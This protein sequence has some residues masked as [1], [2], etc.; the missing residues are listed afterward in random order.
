MKCT[1]AM[2][3]AVVAFV[4]LSGAWLARDAAAEPILDDHSLAPA[5]P[6]APEK[7]GV[8]EAWALF[9]VQDYNGAMKLLREAAATDPSLPPALLI[10]AEWYEGVGRL[11]ESKEVIDQAAAE[12][13]NDPE[14]CLF[15]ARAALRDR[16]PAKA[17]S[18]YEKAQ[19]LVA[20]FDKNPR[21]KERMEKQ[22]QSGQ[23]ALAM[24]TKDW[25]SAQKA[26]EA[27]LKANPKNVL[28]LR[29]L[30]YCL[31]QQKNPDGAL[32]KLQEAAK[33]DPAASAPQAQLS[34]F[35]QASGDLENARKWMAAAVDAAPKDLKT[36]LA[37]GQLAL[38]TGDVEDARKQANAAMQI[39]PRSADA[40][41]FRGIIAML[42]REY[43][44]AE[45]YFS[46][47]LKQ[48]PENFAYR[49]NL[50][51]ALIAQD[52]KAKNQRA[53]DMAEANARQYPKSA[54]AAA[55]LGW[56]LY[57]LGR[58]DEAERA[59]QGAAAIAISDV[60]AAYFTARVAVDRGRKAEARQMLE[61]AL[62]NPK[63]YVFRRDA[64]T[65]LKQ[66]QK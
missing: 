30:A 35:Y 14:V 25:A 29:R 4:A 12:L 41:F 49:N 1:L 55:T 7:T 45:S 13:P 20:A 24:A 10:M 54:D 23:I 43:E 31:F 28:A 57:R 32:A 58:I 53:L 61:S 22:L 52:D 17:A 37:A 9:R 64:E 16:D 11:K 60:D 44:G 63:P 36:R 42:E 46:S 66:L 33:L 27:L 56:A 6:V 65:L 3:L 40:K 59:M 34:Q 21:R 15:L 18:L 38:D 19:G 26:F 39:A 51:F 48:S 47:V 5:V 62:K 8:G 2:R 50:V